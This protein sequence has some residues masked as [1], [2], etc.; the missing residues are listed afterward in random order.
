MHALKARRRLILA[1]VALMTL[2]TLALFGGHAEAHPL[3]QDRL[4]IAPD[5]SDRAAFSIVVTSAIGTT[6]T[7][8]GREPR[9]G[10]FYAPDEVSRAVAD[11]LPYLLA[12]LHVEIDHVP[13]LPGGAEVALAEPVTR[14]VHRLA[15]EDRVRSRTV[16]RYRA[17]SDA[18]RTI[19]L[20]HD[21]LTDVVDRN[22]VRWSLDYVIADAGN[23]PRVLRAD[24]PLELPF[25]GAGRTRGT[26]GTFASFFREGVFHILTGFDHLLFLAAIV[27]GAQR[28]RSLFFV[29]GAFTVAH[30]LTLTLA[31][32]GI[33]RIP[34]AVVE[35]LIGASIVVAA[36]LSLTR[37]RADTASDRERERG[38]IAVA[39]VFGLVHGLGFA[40]DL[41]AALAEDRSHLVL[42][43]AAFTLGIE[44]VQQGLVLP[45]YALIRAARARARGALV[46]EWATL[47]VVVLGVLLVIQAL[48][49][50]G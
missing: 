14:P 4:E 39:F 46:I 12:H 33:V 7:A 37:L 17:Q 30:T 45:L 36:A 13:V 22:G 19:T 43:L 10:A 49:R 26:G 23:A 28:A 11:G 31:T 29:V 27:L 47:V 6:M 24:E 20:R 9:A 18:P 2:M 32:M 25:P 1:T 50:G 44:L 38:R 48:K 42:A 16:L 5:P 8:L 41:T 21:M 34:A 3:H 40:S 15:D 35:P